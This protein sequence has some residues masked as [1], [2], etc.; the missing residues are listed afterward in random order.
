MELRY[1][2]LGRVKL[3]L[4]LLQGRGYIF[5]VL[6]YMVMYLHNC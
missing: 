5:S 3:S 2:A 1:G 4:L 6:Q